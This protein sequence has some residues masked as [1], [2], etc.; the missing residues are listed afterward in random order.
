MFQMPQMIIFKTH[1]DIAKYIDNQLVI[2]KTIGFV[3]TMGA[4]HQGHISLVEASNK[5]MDITITSIFVNPTQFNNT[6]DFAKYPI[7]TNQDIALLEAA[8]CDVLYLPTVEQVY[9][10]GVHNLKQYNL[11]S[12]ETLLEGAFRP[13]H[14]QGVCNVLD[15]L[16]TTIKPHQV[17]MGLKDFQQCA[18]VGK[19]LAL[20]NSTTQLV[21]CATLR[22][23]SGLAMSSR[24]ARLSPEA[25]ITAAAIYKCLKYINTNHHNGTFETH[26]AEALAMLGAAFNTEYISLLDTKTWQVL[27]NYDYNTT[28]C[29]LIATWHDEVRLID[30]II[31]ESDIIL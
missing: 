9:P 29:V 14:F 7:T 24:N 23:T 5:A 11:E 4:L 2:G 6:T 30:N 17:F 28:M 1:K 12:I 20:T 13:G 3:P 16:F 31:L 8:K 19:L 27:T 18:V 25:K 22:E 10:N 26:K 21:T 15:N